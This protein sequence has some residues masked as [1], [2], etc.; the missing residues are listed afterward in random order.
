[1]PNRIGAATLPEIIISDVAQAKKNKSIKANIA[2]ALF[3]AIENALAEQ[4][5]VILFQNRRGYA[6]QLSCDFCGWTQQCI[7]CDLS[8]TY[9][10][11]SNSLKCHCCGYSATQVKECPGCGSRQLSVKGFGTERIEEDIELLYN[12]AIVQRMDWDT[13]KTK[14]AH[15]NIITAFE[16]GKTNIL[17]GTQMVTK[18]LDFANVKVV[19]VILADNLFYFPNF[20]A[21]ERA[22]QLLTQVAGRAGRTDGE[23]VVIIQAKNV[24]H[25]VLQEVVNNDFKGFYSREITERQDFVYP[26]FTRLIQITIKHKDIDKLEQGVKRFLDLIDPKFVKYLNGPTPPGVPRMRNYYLEVGLFKLPRKKEIIDPL[27][28]ELKRIKQDITLAR[29]L[30]QLRFIIDVDPV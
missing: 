8:L 4:K 7:H 12:D 23:G 6:P 16:E 14:N 18:G 15:A 10:M 24:T 29:G 20:R 2:P 21:S 25:P 3:G 22:F 5:Q 1:M 13:V 28:E 30:S 11:H 17:I 9:H 27:K 26:P 19:G